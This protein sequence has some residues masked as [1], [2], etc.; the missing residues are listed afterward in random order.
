MTIR[1]LIRWGRRVGNSPFQHLQQQQQQQ[2]KQQQ[3]QQQEQVHEYAP[4]SF[5]EVALE[6][7]LLVG[8][9][10]RTEEDR[11]VVRASLERHCLGSTATKPKH[12][13]FTFAADPYVSAFR[14]LLHRKIQRC[15]QQQQAAADAAAAAAAA[16]AHAAALSD[17]PEGVRREA[18]AAA[19]AAAATAAA[20][21]AA[22][23]ELPAFL[24]FSFNAAS[25]RLL[26]LTLR[27][28]VAGENLLLV[29]DTGA[30]K[31]AVC[32]LV[33]WTLQQE[34]Q[35]Q[36]QLLLQQQGEEGPTALEK[37][38][39]QR[40][41]P[42]GMY[43][44]NCHLQMEA[45]ELLGC[46]TPVHQGELMQ[47]QQHA[48]AL[49]QQILEMLEHP[50]PPEDLLPNCGQLTQSSATAA[51]ATAAGAT[52][53]AAAGE[54]GSE[55]KSVTADGL[56]LRFYELLQAAAADVVICFRAHKDRGGLEMGEEDTNL[57]C[58]A[59]SK[60]A[61]Q[62]QQL[63]QQETDAAAAAAAEKETHFSQQLEVARGTLQHE[64]SKHQQ[65]LLQLQQQE[66][67]EQQQQ[68]QQKKQQ[69]EQ[70]VAGADGGTHLRQHRQQ[71]Q[72]EQQEQQQ[73]QQQQLQGQEGKAARK[74]RRK[75]TRNQAA[76]ETE[77]AAAEAAGAAQD[78]EDTAL[79]RL[80]RSSLNSGAATAT[81]TATAARAEAKGSVLHGDAAGAT[82]A[83]AA[84]ED[85]G[86][87][88][89]AREALAA[90]AAAASA[91]AVSAEEAVASAA[92]SH[93]AA[94]ASVVA[95][96][97]A[98]GAAAGMVKAYTDQL[99]QQCAAWRDACKRTRCLF[100]WRD[101]PLVKAMKEGA[102][103]LLDEASLGQDA[104]LER[105]N[106]L[107]EDGRHILLTE[108]GA[109]AGAA[110]AATAA[111]G[112]V[113][114]AAAA[115]A[116]AGVEVHAAA[117]FRFIATM[118]PGGDYGKRE[119]SPALRN[120]L[121]EVYVPAFSFD[122][123]DAVLLLLQ[124]LQHTCLRGLQLPYAA[125]A[126][127]MK[128]DNTQM[129]QEL[130]QLKQQL[131]Q[132]QQQQQQPDESQGDLLLSC[133]AIRLVL[134]LRWVRQHIK[135]PLSIRDAL[136]WIC[137]IHRFVASQ[138]HAA[139]NTPAAGAATAAARWAVQGLIHGGCLLLLDGLGVGADMLLPQQ[140]LQALAEGYFETEANLAALHASQGMAEEE[141]QVRLQQVQQ[142][143][144]Q[145]VAEAAAHASRRP[146][147]GVLL[148]LKMHACGLYTDLG[149]YRHPDLQKQQQQQQQQAKA[150][151][152][153]W[154]ETCAAFEEDG[155]AWVS[156]AFAARGS[157][158]AS[159]EE[160]ML[161]VGPFS[162]A[163]YKQAPGSTL[164]QQ[165]QQQQKQ[166]QQQQQQQLQRVDE[167]PQVIQSPSVR[168][169][170][171]RLLRC[172]L[173][174]QQQQQQ[175]GGC[176]GSSSGRHAVLLEGPPG[177]GKTFVVG[178]LARLCGRQLVRINLSQ[179]TELADLLGAVVPAAEIEDEEDKTFI[180]PTTPLHPSAAAAA[181][182]A[183]A[184]AA[185]DGDAGETQAQTPQVERKKPPFV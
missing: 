82:S 124:R 53:T 40:L 97:A 14:R 3:K 117:G 62:A 67:E 61:R 79:K 129:Q 113:A 78:V 92:S 104:V 96:H 41:S 115:A 118:N 58:R 137:F 153:C 114:P 145:Q 1:D 171:G 4:M 51:A 121:T 71:Q 179:D 16:A 31:T 38:L 29:G 26:A 13:H 128:K 161:E 39:V 55:E 6:G 24:P 86:S 167:L 17:A 152:P 57:F 158:A 149:L 36:Q 8:E 7:W 56:L 165:Q 5:E 25:L 170:L 156:A 131:Q 119:L 91:A 154:S 163:A 142:K 169:S 148:L 132:Q 162:L 63:L 12:L 60:A 180:T 178:L 80:R 59:L 27:A 106:S 75:G 54:G 125:E 100:C 136:C 120:R 139:P 93:A 69:E 73:H 32:E 122:A 155:F 166:Q 94:A 174:L 108:Q 111:D 181:P 47:Q 109:A 65:L 48:A 66:Q 22:A 116:T 15:L 44:Y 168:R 18:E 183:A 49:L 184:A 87:A 159:E 185:A 146:H 98:A 133:L 89:A 151:G 84:K 127:A 182:T 76:K 177:A 107:L 134:L 99:L 150:A 95:L 112:S 164:Q 176:L 144:Q 30:G 9:R 143:L 126:L 101:G 138:L 43:V 37:G 81:A 173:L 102:V 130:L 70:D 10:L 50:P 68:K 11:A 141:Q 83:A 20:A 74:K 103:F 110:T 135:Q 46:M 21:A 157:I 23:P 45:S 28:M 72:Q 105:L 35:Q 90:A 160:E 172:L 123:P 2:Q 175:G 147:L 88:A 64:Q 77:A 52:A 33:A 42:N 34:P 140:Q 19:A 85:A